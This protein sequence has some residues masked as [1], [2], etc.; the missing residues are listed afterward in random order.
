MG[1]EEP[2]RK[3]VLSP[4]RFGNPTIKSPKPVAIANRPI[5]RWSRISRPHASLIS[6]HLIGTVRRCEVKPIVAHPAR[7][8]VSHWPYPCHLPVAPVRGT[9][10]RSFHCRSRQLFQRMG[11][12]G[13][14]RQKVADCRRID[15]GVFFVRGRQ[16]PGF[17]GA[18]DQHGVT[19]LDAR[20]AVDGGVDRDVGDV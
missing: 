7:P 15:L 20:S 13:L 18:P 6:G 2:W 14:A 9:S 3:R 5:S 11:A 17:A 16:C 4:R 12:L 10:Q 1:S 19:D 8:C